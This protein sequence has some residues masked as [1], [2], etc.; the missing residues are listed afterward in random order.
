MSGLLVI[1]LMAAVP[2]AGGAILKR[3]NQ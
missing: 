2:W 3:M 1:L